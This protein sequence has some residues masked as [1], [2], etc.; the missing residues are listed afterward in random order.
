MSAV[1]EAHRRH[2][3]HHP[4][5]RRRGRSWST[6]KREETLS[7]GE[8]QGQGSRQLTG[9]FFCPRRGAKLEKGERREVLPGSKAP[10]IKTIS[11]LQARTQWWSQYSGYIHFSASYGFKMAVPTAVLQHL[12]PGPLLGRMSCLLLHKANAESLHQALFQQHFHLFYAF[13]RLSICGQFVCYLRGRVAHVNAFY[14]I[15]G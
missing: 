15:V 13:L 4:S 9:T 3:H 7:E 12:L 11:E 5:P 8:E 14:T 2:H 10:Y 1:N 6:A